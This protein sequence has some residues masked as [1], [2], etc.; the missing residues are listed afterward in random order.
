MTGEEVVILVDEEGYALGTTPKATVHHRSTPLHLAFSCY[1][2]DPDER[3]LVTRRALHKPTWP[4]V[5]TNSFCGHPGPGEELTAGVRRRAEQELGLGLDSL[6]L[7]LP[8]FRYRAT[9]ANG[10]R[11]NELCP[12]FVATT[13]GP[14]SPDPAE[15]DDHTWEDWAT[16]R[17]AVLAGRRDVSPWCVEQVAALAAVEERPVQF[18]PGSAADLPPAAQGVYGASSPLR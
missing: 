15:V 14:A 7:T 18:T 8:A 10:V 6:Q 3:L 4:G 13:A 1:V 2:L 9:M 12:V 5:W 11:E 17:E 16:F